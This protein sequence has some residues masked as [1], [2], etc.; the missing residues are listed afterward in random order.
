MKTDQD[1][2]TKQDDRVRLSVVVPVYMGKSFLAELYA[3]VKQ[4]VSSIGVDFELILVND[5]S[6]DQC[7]DDIVKLCALDGRVKGLNLSRN[8]GQ[9]YAITAGL[10][11]AT[12]EWIVVMDCDLQDRPED[13]P[14]LLTKASE[15][16][17]SVFARRVERHDSLFKRLQSRVFYTLL[18][19]LTDT[20]IDCS[21]ANFGVYN[22]KVVAAVLSMQDRV[23]FFPALVQWVGFKKAFCSVTHAERTGSGSSYTLGK[24]MKLAG[25]NM[26]AFSDKPLRLC[27]RFGFGISLLSFLIATICLFARIFNM[28]IVSGFTS[29]MISVW[30]V[31]GI[32]L[33]SLGLVG[34]YVGKTFDQ[35]KGRPTFI[36]AEC[37]NGEKQV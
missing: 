18:G 24:L 22:R 7:W 31:G 16:Y 30:F 2:A 19:Y 8:F 21:I 37:V 6:P 11:Y 27:V 3:R 1:V 23:R 17:D 25:E 32:I 35:V 4:S 28:I 34:V 26:I 33:M 36:V 10:A 5:A 12:G 15:G 20:K 14:A 29:L 13:I 9:H